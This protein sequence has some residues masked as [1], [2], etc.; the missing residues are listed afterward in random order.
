MW[1]WTYCERDI[2]IVS[3]RPTF[4]ESFWAFLVEKR[5]KTADNVQE[6]SYNVEE[7]I[8]LIVHVHAS[9]TKESQ[10]LKSLKWNK[11]K[12]VKNNLIIF[13]LKSLIKLLGC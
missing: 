12:I 4:H 3:E 2:A 9:K 13:F 7:R 8:V 6:R 11:Q 1:T 10:R 5:S